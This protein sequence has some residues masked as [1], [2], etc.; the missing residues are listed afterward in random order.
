MSSRSPMRR[1]SDWS[2]SNPEAACAR[3]FLPAGALFALRHRETLINQL[4]PGPAE[5][6]LFRLLVRWRP[7][8]N[9]RREQPNAE[10]ADGWTALV[11]P[12]RALTRVGPRAVIW[13]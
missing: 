1:G 6:G 13:R 5:D 10:G 8:G 11:G 9:A 4:L 3:S 2:S 12:G 7:D